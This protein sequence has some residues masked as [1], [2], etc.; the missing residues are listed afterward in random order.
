MS[1]SIGR[2][3]SWRC[4][5]ARQSP[6]VRPG[7]GARWERTAHIT[8]T[9]RTRRTSGTATI[10]ARVWWYRN[11]GSKLPAKHSTPRIVSRVQQSVA[12]RSG[13]TKVVSADFNNADPPQRDAGESAPEPGQKGEWGRERGN[14]NDKDYDHHLSRRPSHSAAAPTATMAIVQKIGTQGAATMLARVK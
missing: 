6:P 12:R 11:P 1:V 14:G 9:A 5:S 2:K 4:H 13:K 3:V 10:A 8:G 7:V